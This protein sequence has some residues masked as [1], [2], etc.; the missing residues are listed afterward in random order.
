MIPYLPEM[1]QMHTHCMSGLTLCTGNMRH[2]DFWANREYHKLLQPINWES[3]AARE[4]QY[5]GELGDVRYWN[6]HNMLRQ[7]KIT[8][9]TREE[10]TTWRTTQRTS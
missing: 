6:M 1:G 10:V 2:Q 3:F 4:F 9:M 5:V 8:G 7:L